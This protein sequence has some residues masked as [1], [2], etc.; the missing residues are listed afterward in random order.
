MPSQS[1]YSIE[2]P[3]FG[4]ILLGKSP[5]NLKSFQKPLRELYISYYQE[6]FHDQRRIIIS[7]CDI[8]IFE[9][10]A[11]IKGKHT[12]IYSS[13]E[14]IVDIQILKLYIM[15]N[16]TENQ[17]HK[18]IQAAF[19]PIG[20]EH[21]QCFRSFYSIINKSQYN[22][23][24]TLT[25]YHPSLLL[26]FIRKP[27]VGNSCSLI[28]CHVFEIHPE[29]KAFDLCNM[30]RKLIIKRT[31][32]PM[33][34]NRTTLIRT[35]NNDKEVKI[36][37]RTKYLE[38]DRL[39]STMEYHQTDNQTITEEQNN[40]ILS[41]VDS[42]DVVHLTTNTPRNP[43]S[44]FSLL[45]NNV[46]HPPPFHDTSKVL[47]MNRDI[48]RM[49]SPCSTSKQRHF[50]QASSLIQDESDE[51]VHDLLNI[52][53]IEQ[54]KSQVSIKRQAS[55]DQTSY[56]DDNKMNKKRY[57]HNK[58]RLL[59][60]IPT[61]NNITHQ[62]KFNSIIDG[63]LLRPQFVLNHYG[64]IGNY[65]PKFLR[66]NI[67]MRSSDSNENIFFRST[68]GQLLNGFLKLDF[69]STKSINGYNNNNNNINNNRY[70]STPY[71]NPD[72]NIYSLVQQ[73]RNDQTKSFINI[74]QVNSNI[75]NRMFD[76]KTNSTD[77]DHRVPYILKSIEDVKHGNKVYPFTSNSYLHQHP[78]KLNMSSSSSKPKRVTSFTNGDTELPVDYRQ[79]L[80]HTDQGA[81]LYGEEQR[82][83]QQQTTLEH[84][85][86]YFP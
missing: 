12:F 26:F 54:I 67:T 2:L 24:S 63:H 76:M 62:Q 82:Q 15:V 75:S 73:L 85:L 41:N 16:N 35:K 18:H 5:L 7:D 74:H 66:E 68:N 11:A 53:A 23:L 58:K 49:S 17:Q 64:D 48:Y 60:S 40:H 38:P 9:P 69:L 3:Y 6:Q 34:S 72:Q 78:S 56:S 83:Q 65:V 39:M 22:L 20:S 28:D 29:S 8:L 13:F 55:F 10:N 31:M 84:S 43:L 1:V 42:N 21:Q 77:D 71:L 19:L 86:G 25:S 45:I 81:Y 59:K 33:L 36:E 27:G 30:I 44:S 14:S 79:Y 80:R 37:K 50:I 70:Q 57:F 51:I 47:T 46:Q 52:V 61:I 32:S 4:A